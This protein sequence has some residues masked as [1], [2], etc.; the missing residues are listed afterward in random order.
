MN[1]D[2]GHNTSCQCDS[3]LY[4]I[5]LKSIQN[6]QNMDRTQS[7]NGCCKTIVPPNTGGHLNKIR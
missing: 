5:V 1:L 7:W 3:Y 2:L 6:W 4:T